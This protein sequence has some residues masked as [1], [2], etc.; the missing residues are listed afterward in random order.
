MS[1]LSDQCCVISST[2]WAEVLQFITALDEG[3]SIT[4]MA[5]PSNK[6]KRTKDG[7]ISMMQSNSNKLRTHR[8]SAKV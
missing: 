5:Q 8:V 1:L 7:A 2:M 4:M 3:I 6:G